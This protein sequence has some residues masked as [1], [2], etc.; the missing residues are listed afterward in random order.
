MMPEIIVEV[1]TDGSVVIEGK[2][3][4]G[5]ECRQATAAI[6]AALGDVIKVTPKPELRQ[7]VRAGTGKAVGR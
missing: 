3:F 5:A 1:D 2:G 6:E 4:I 7:G